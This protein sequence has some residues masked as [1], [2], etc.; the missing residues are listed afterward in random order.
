MRIKIPP[1]ASLPDR[2]PSSACQIAYVSQPRPSPFTTVFL[3][4]I[5]GMLCAE[6][7]WCTCLLCLTTVNRH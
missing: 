7:A 2:H 1:H 4:A 3:I 6:A 5:N